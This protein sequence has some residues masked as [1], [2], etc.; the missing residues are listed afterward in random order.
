MGIK[1]G[2]S[3]K[4]QCGA[5]E[6]A[7]MGIIWY[8]NWIKN[9]ISWD[10]TF[11]TMVLQPL[12]NWNC[13]K[14]PPVIWQFANWKPW[15]VWFDDFRCKK[16]WF[17]WVQ[18]RQNAGRT[19]GVG[20]GDNAQSKKRHNIQPQNDGISTCTDWHTIFLARS[21]RWNHVDDNY[22]N[23]LNT[24]SPSVHIKIIAG[25][26]GKTIDLWPIS[27][28]HKP[29]PSHHHFDVWYSRHPQMVSLWQPG[30]PRLNAIRHLQNQE[31][32]HG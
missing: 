1:W 12:T 16:W 7:F 20:V 2:I 19:W 25:V 22:D 29:S 27:Q 17:S 5:V 14:H 32:N 24:W 8:N 13:S 6:V 18:K 9:I 11:L 23:E 30:F 3:W 31:I 4:Y 28:C 21:L 15:P 10:N 26:H